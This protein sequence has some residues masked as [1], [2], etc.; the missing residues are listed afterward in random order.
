M[1]CCASLLAAFRFLTILPLPWRE[2]GPR[3]LGR[4]V[5]WFPLVGLAMGAVLAA[6]DWLASPA[7]PA[8]V[9]AGLVMVVWLVANGAIHFDGFLDTCDGL[10]GGRTPEQRLDIMRDHR[11]GAFAVAGGILLLLMQYSALTSLGSRTL[12]LLLAPML[13]RWAIALAIV[14]F[15]YARE[16]GLG[17]AMKDEAEWPQ[18]LLATGIALAA[19]GLAGGWMGMAAMLA[20]GAAM[21]AAAAFIQTRIPGLTGD[22]Y[23]AIVEVVEVIVLM[24]FL[25]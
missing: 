24:V 4:A 15:P 16:Q 2:T 11:V 3:D 14:L 5:G 12:P 7:L 9:V 8:G 21:L 6:I 23:G 25:F 17:R 13:G 10:F 19:A 20:A 1:T 22:S 18:A